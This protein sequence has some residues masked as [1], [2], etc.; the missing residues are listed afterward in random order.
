MFLLIF[1]GG[2]EI[3]REGEIIRKT[4]VPAH[5]DTGVRYQY[6]FFSEKYELHHYTDH[7]PDRWYIRF[8][9]MVDE[10]TLEYQE[11][12]LSVDKGTYDK[13]ELHDWITFE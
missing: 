3:I 7:V 1:M 11:R 5:T 10:Q 2:C 9:K 4:F 13:H 8:K 6:N 12:E